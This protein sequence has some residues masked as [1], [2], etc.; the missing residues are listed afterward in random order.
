MTTTNPDT[1]TILAEPSTFTLQNGLKVEVQRIQTR[2]LLR[3]LKIISNGAGP[4]FSD[5]DLTNPDEDFASTLLV[6][7]ALALPN[8]E[9]ETIEFLTSMVLPADFKK[10]RGLSKEEIEANQAL[11]DQLNDEFFNPDLDDLVSLLEI[12]RD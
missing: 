9:D 11:L 4:A 10:G 12:D 3:L 8:A 1:D 2:Q 5:L 6:A 7:I